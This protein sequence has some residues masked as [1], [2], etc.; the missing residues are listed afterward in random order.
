[1]GF[2]GLGG[3]KTKPEYTGLATQ[4]S[5][6]NIAIAIVMGENRG[7]PNIIWQ[8]DFQAHKHS[9]GGKGGGGKGGSTYTYSGSFW[10]ALC[11][12]P[13]HGIG[14]VYKDKEL[15][16]LAALGFTLFTGTTPQSPWGY[17]TTAHPSEA[18]G[19]AGI[20]GCTKANY[21]LGSSNALSQH[22]FEI[23]GLLW[24][25]AT[26]TGGNDADIGLGIQAYIS[27]PTWGVGFDTSF[28]NTDSLLSTPAAAT[29]G[30]NALQ[31]YCQA[32]GWGFSPNLVDQ[33]AASDTI[34]R[35]CDLFNAAPI[36]TGYNLK[37]LPYCTESITANGVT[38]LPSFPVAYVITDD[39]FLGDASADPISFDRADPADCKNQFQI[40]ISNKANQYND[41]P[42]MWEDLALI[43]Q[44][45]VKPDSGFEAKEITS[46]TMAQQ[47]VAL[48]GQRNTYVRNRFALNLGV[49]FMRLEPGDIIQAVDPVLGTL[50]LMVE[51]IT[52]QDDDSLDLVAFEWNDSVTLAPTIPTQPVSGNNVDTG[53]AASA[54]N[55]PIL[56]EP[57]STLAGT[58][59][60][61]AAVSG[62]N[63]TTADPLWGGCNVW[64]STDNATYTQIGT[65]NEPARMGVTTA[66]LA[67]YGGS[68]PDAGHTLSVNLAE[69][70][71]ALISASSAADAAAGANLC[72][73]GGEF[74]SPQTVTPTATYAFN[75][76]NLYR[77]LYGSTAGSHASGSPIA[78]L[79]GNVF[80][81]DLP[82]A[83]IGIT[84]Y[85][86][87]QS[88]NVYG[89]G[90]QD[91][92]TCTAYT[93]TTTG[94]GFGT[95][96]AGAPA[97]P[98]G[99]SATA[100]YAQVA[101]SWTANVAN[102]NVT[103]YEVWRANGTGASFGSASKIATV[104]G[105]AYTDTGLAAS[106]GY[107]Y[108]LKAVNIVG[109]SSP[110]GGVNATTSA[111]GFGGPSAT[112]TT[113]E[114]LSAGN[115][116][117]IY[118]SGGAARV[119]KANATD[120]TKPANAFVLAS[121]GSGA[122]ATTYFAGSVITGLTSLTPGTTYWLDTT[123]GAVT[124]TPPSG[125]GNGVQEI[126]VALSATT[127]LF[128]P[129][130]MI[131]L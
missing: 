128:D 102:D 15:T 103:S 114:A 69:S 20:A 26:W 90:V 67:A 2:L 18:L 81:Y 50:T 118:T 71:G 25:T 119:Q 60:V 76:T 3:H 21:D 73:V 64:I 66:T 38:Y 41:L 49:N 54:V 88:F 96:T 83:Y 40:T 87:F 22:S 125:S 16:T 5:T 13:I 68:N 127:L 72:Y 51:E 56:F 78:R 8:G 42:V 116:C 79:D 107:T 34:K 109:P 82:A 62:G 100:G 33:T 10:L 36:W 80:K 93:I 97:T 61:W 113:S 55:T 94:A 27:D 77:A 75:C 74:V 31:T 111:T 43:D 110:T 47:M 131:G 17:L 4:T 29:T 44:Y 46:E 28:L 91:L 35:W 7:S 89:G 129:Q 58:P 70:A 48:Y 9:A 95:G 117:N 112:I 123:G 84:L 24:N 108:F 19:Y 63:G 124:A 39:D 105:L 1:V 126:G 98:T 121:V 99:L 30:D 104:A 52:E 23:Q 130:P 12:G 57:P 32:M 86:K 92:S 65:I 120:L 115:V 106:T 85:L 11:W 37:F 101:L 6:S 59:Q 14:T 122:S 45:G 53:V